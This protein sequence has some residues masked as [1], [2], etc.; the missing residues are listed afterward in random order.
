MRKRGGG[1]EEEENVLRVFW[2]I[3]GCG[4]GGDMGKI[5]AKLRVLWLCNLLSASLQVVYK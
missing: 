2:G 3:I 4:K 1:L 5:S